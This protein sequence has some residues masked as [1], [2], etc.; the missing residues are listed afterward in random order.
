MDMTLTGIHVPL[1]TPFTEQG[2]IAADALERLAHDVLGQGAAGLVALGTT[3]EAATL[4]GAERDEVVDVCARVCRAHGVPLTVGAGSADT[5]GAVP[6]LERLARWPQT[7]AALVAVP[8]FTRPGP[9]GVLAHFTHLAAHSPVPL[10][11][12]HVPYRTGQQLDAAALRALGR[13]PAVVGVKYAAGFD[14]T[15]V[16]LLADLP[17]DFAV[18]AGDDSFVSPM[19]ALGAP[20]AIMASAHLAT[21]DFAALAAAW[22]SGDVPAARALGHRLSAVSAAVFAEP[23]PTVVKGVLHAQGRIPSPAV[24]LPLLPASRDSV[25]RALTAVARLRR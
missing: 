12:Y 22:R 2:G 4:S 23:N 16:D 7:T 24:R 5:L 3:A 9:A 10:I 11:V 15:V 17:P 21:A 6:V 20:G 25:D 19:L 1:V 18:L 14:Q 13:L 8:A